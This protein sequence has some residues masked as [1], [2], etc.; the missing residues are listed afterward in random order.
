MHQAPKMLLT[1]VFV[2]QKLRNL[3]NLT[4]INWQL[5]Q[6]DAEKIIVSLSMSDMI[7]CLKSV[8]IRSYSG[9]YFPVFGL[10]TKRY[11]VSFHA[12]YRLPVADKRLKLS[13]SLNKKSVT[14]ATPILVSTWNLKEVLTLINNTSSCPEV[15]LWKAVLKI[16][17]KFIGEHPRR[18]GC[19]FAAYFQ[20]TFS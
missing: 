12:V 9:P 1:S 6:N 10:N 16:C 2:Q 4:N 7:H 11:G 8:C 15:Y 17:S 20:N 13:M 3:L 18:S 19:I 14:A 5:L